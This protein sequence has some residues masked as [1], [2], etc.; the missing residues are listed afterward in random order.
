M[1][2]IAYQKIAETIAQMKM[3]GYDSM[4]MEIT[5]KDGRLFERL[6]SEAFSDRRAEHVKMSNETITEFSL[7]ILGD[8][9]KFKRGAKVK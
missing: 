7:Y 9:I 8:E 3:A 5:L 1:N 2:S 4:S 6:M